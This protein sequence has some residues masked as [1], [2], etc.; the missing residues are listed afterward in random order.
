MNISREFPGELTIEY[1]FSFL[2]SKIPDHN[3]VLTQR[4]NN[5]KR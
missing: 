4:D 2:T 1:L 5:V 3:K